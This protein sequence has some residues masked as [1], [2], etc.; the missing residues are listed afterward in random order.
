MTA[1]ARVRALTASPARVLTVTKATVR[2]DLAQALHVRSSRPRDVEWRGRCHIYPKSRRLRAL[3]VLCGE[4]QSIVDEFRH[5]R[6]VRANRQLHVD[7]VV[8]DGKLAVDRGC[9]ERDLRLV[10]ARV[11]SPLS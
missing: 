2:D 7:R 9:R 5:V 6:V 4:I 1:L 8:D 3:V 10:D 11:L